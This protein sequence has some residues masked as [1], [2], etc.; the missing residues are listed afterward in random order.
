MKR[1]RTSKRKVILW[2]FL[3]LFLLIAGAA[4]GY[5]AFLTNK[6]KDAANNAFQELNRGSKSI[7]RP[8]EVDPN[9]D[10]ISI[11]FLGI[12][13]SEARNFTEKARTD[14]MVLATFNVNEKSV[15]LVSIPRDSY[16]MIPS[17]G[18]KDKINHAHAFGGVDESVKTVEKL[19]DIPVDYY[20]RLNFNAFVET[21]NALG[22]IEYDVPFD[23]SEKNSADVSGAVTLKEGI[24]TING[25]EALALA[26]T[27]KYDSDMKRGQRQMDLMKSIFD[28]A[29]SLQ[30]V[31]KYSPLIDSIGSNMKTNMTF[32][33]M[34]AL[35]DYIL[36]RKNISFDTMQ[37][38]GKHA[39][40]DDIYYYK[41]VDTSISQ[42]KNNLQAHMELNEDNESDQDVSEYA[43]DKEKEDQEDNM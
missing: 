21:V 33:E 31:T 25:E 32:D 23:M 1:K 38:E 11:L 39:Y 19:F 24:Q 37:L 28:K 10:N 8:D 20:V 22:G 7:D 35:K 13:D 17:K 3:V 41:L 15:K 9:Y 26:R 42:I 12:D 14:A 40:I 18:F 43:D 2:S 4:G 30:S 27:R 16:V 34:I 6:A 29:S 5:A 36:N